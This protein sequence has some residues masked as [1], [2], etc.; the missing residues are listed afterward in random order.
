MATLTPAAR[1]PSGLI[2]AQIDGSMIPIL[3]PVRVGV[4]RRRERAV[5]WRELKACLARDRDWATP[6]FGATLGSV[7][8]AGLL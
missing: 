1:P 7:Q 2:V 8:V 4:D 6:L 3:Q 5:D